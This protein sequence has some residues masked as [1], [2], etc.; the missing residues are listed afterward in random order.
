[1]LKS[2]IWIVDVIYASPLAS[3]YRTKPAFEFLSSRPP[4]SLIHYEAPRSSA[5]LRRLGFWPKRPHSRPL[6][7]HD[8]FSKPDFR[9]RGRQTCECALVVK[10][11]VVR[12]AD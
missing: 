7:G 3:I 10:Y 8:R 12:H 2:M 5:L 6:R 4:G 9:R 11:F 1:M